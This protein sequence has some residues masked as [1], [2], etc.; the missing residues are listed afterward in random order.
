MILG[1]K[2]LVRIYNWRNLSVTE[3]WT[4]H[5]FLKDIWLYYIINL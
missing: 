1:D 2:Q 3:I 4:D 5:F